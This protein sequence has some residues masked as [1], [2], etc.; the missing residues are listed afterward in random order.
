MTARIRRKRAVRLHELL[1]F[2]CMYSDLKPIKALSDFS[3]NAISNHLLR[4]TIAPY[5][6]A[7]CECYADHSFYIKRNGT[8]QIIPCLLQCRRLNLWHNCGNLLFCDSF[9]YLFH[10]CP[11]FCGS[12]AVSVLCSVIFQIAVVA[13]TITA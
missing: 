5:S 11:V 1:V 13:Y 4:L 9:R 6:F 2:H 12:A 8:Q 3:H 7:I 10:F